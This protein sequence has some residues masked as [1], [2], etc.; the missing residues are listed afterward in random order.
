M[1]CPPHHWL[2]GAVV[3]QLPN[4]GRGHWLVERAATCKNCPAARTFRE[5]EFTDDEEGKSRGGAVP[6]HDNEWALAKR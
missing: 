1:T 3:G 4:S 6:L 2:M 5:R